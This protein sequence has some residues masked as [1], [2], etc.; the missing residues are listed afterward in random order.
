[1]RAEIGEMGEH[2]VAS[3][4]IAINIDEWAEVQHYPRGL[5]NVLCTP[6][7]VSPS[8]PGV[9]RLVGRLGKARGVFLYSSLH[10]TLNINQL[11]KVQHVVE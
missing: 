3:I 6:M 1:M 8:P 11:F 7:Q 5:A 2:G 10:Y 4:Y 9:N